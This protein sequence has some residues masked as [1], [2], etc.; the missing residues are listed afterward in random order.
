MEVIQSS[1]GGPIM[2]CQFPDIRVDATTSPII[3]SRSIES[4][5]KEENKSAGSNNHNSN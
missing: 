4:L 5:E 2:V 1:L 3:E